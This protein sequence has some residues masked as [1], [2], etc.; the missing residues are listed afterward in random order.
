[1]FRKMPWILALLIALAV[2]L[3]PL[4]PNGVQ[5]AFYG[6][7]LSI[8]NLIVFLL[9]VV[10]FS[11]LFR[12]VLQLSKK[13]SKMILFLF[14]AIFLSNI[15]STL[16]SG[17][18]GHLIY[19]A[20]GEIH[21]PENLDR[22]QPLWQWTFPK[23]ISTGM[24]MLLGVGTSI[25]LKMVRPQLAEKWGEKL[26]PIVHYLLKT[27]LCL[28][29][30]F[31]FGFV[32][33]MV[34]DGVMMHIVEHYAW[35]LGV[36]ALAAFSYITLLY[37]FACRFNISQSLQSMK[38]MFPAVAAGFG[39]MSSAAAMPMT[40]IAAEKNNENPEVAKSVTAATVN[41]HLIGDC[42]AIP[43]FAFA[44]MSSF[45]IAEP[46]VWSYLTF[47]FY[48][49][50]AKF[51]VAAVPGGG[52]LVMLPILESTLGFDGAMLSLVTALYF[53]FDPIITSANVFGNGAFT[54]HL[55][56]PFKRSLETVKD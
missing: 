26:D 11:M 42:F 12:A 20:G 23:W 50:I 51:S 3:E 5:A 17:S 19:G 41:V 13:A 21:V 31:L 27:F 56:N 38:N 29:P 18:V 9:P 28:I 22:L 36:V 33:K 53:L 46:T 47:A 1:M 4:M 43:I 48:F 25:I 2:L 24:S 6:L 44:I 16:I 32:I 40:L 37:V 10:I 15:V 49:A 14:V 55:S 54:M 35:I 30:F 34:H 7:S 52:V 39:S 8:K 45:G